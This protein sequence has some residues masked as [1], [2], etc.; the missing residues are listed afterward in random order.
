MFLDNRKQFTDTQ[1]DALPSQWKKNPRNL[2]EH[3]DL[4][5]SRKS[6]CKQFYRLLKYQVNDVKK[7][8]TFQCKIRENI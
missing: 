6:C 5:I 2:A 4:L 1:S 8:A 3:S 7:S